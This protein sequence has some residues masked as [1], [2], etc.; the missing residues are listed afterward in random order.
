MPYV[1]LK[2]GNMYQLKNANTGR[3]LKKTF[4]SRE[5]AKN[6]SRNYMRHE[7]SKKDKKTEKKDKGYVR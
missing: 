2:K 1:I 7:K 4:V 3:I 6:A 5:S